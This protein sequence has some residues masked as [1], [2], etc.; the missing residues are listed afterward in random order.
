MTT[1]IDLVNKLRTRFNEVALTNTT[2]TTTVG[3]DQYTKD[4]VNYAYH[5][6]LN[7]EMEWPFL[8]QKATL[9][10]SPGTL[11]YVLAPTPVNPSTPGYTSPVEIKTIDVDKVFISPNATVATITNEAQTIPSTA[12][13]TVAVNGAATWSSNLGVSYAGGAAFEAVIGDPE[14]AGDY[15]ITPAN[16][17]LGTYQFSSADAGAS[18]TISYMT[19]TPAQVAQLENAQYLAPIPYDFWCQN[20]LQQDLDAAP[21]GFALP[22]YIYR[23][24]NFPEIGLSPVP[25]KIYQLNYE[26][27]CDGS[28]MSATTDV[29]LIPS[30]FWNVILDG[31]QK[32]IYEFREDPQQAQLA[33]ARFKAGITRM[34]IELINK[35]EQMNAGVS[36]V[37]G[38][39]YASPFVF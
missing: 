35:E 26:Y 31:A 32:Y 18:I 16:G 14:D 34:R 17:P 23:T 39:G 6:I 24:N 13:F 12:P 27:W 30:H 15:T 37:R 29:P 19:T 2:W 10:T 25:D 9:L 1:Y 33:D 4:A 20:F 7:A 3:L 11:T 22:Q 21:A 28:D 8:H 38:T 5:D 36:W